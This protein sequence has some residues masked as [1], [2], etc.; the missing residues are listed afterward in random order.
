[1]SISSLSLTN[2]CAQA[3]AITPWYIKSRSLKGESSH[4]TNLIAAIFTFILPCCTKNMYTH[5][6]VIRL[7][8]C[9]IILPPEI[10]KMTA[11]LLETELD[12]TWILHIPWTQFFFPKSWQDTINLICQIWSWEQF[13]VDR[14][15]LK[16]CTTVKHNKDFALF[17]RMVHSMVRDIPSLH[18]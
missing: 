18:L 16:F 7:P 3:V 4:L 1:M 6:I 11:G 5:Y 10:L 9:I 15:S 2:G 12:N 8:I 14:L 13:V 17:T